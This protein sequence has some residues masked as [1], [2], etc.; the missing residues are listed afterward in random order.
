MFDLSYGTSGI[1]TA[2]SLLIGI[3]AVTPIYLFKP[4][5][6]QPFSLENNNNSGPISN[7]V[8]IPLGTRI[9]LRH[10]DAERILVTNEES[11]DITLE[12]AANIRDRYGNFLVP[13]GSK[14]MGFIQPANGGAQ[15]VTREIIIYN[16]R[17]PLY[18]SS[19]VVT[20]TETINEGASVE[21]ILGGTL[22]GS[23]AAAIIAGTTGDRRIDALEVLA[24][25]AVGTLAGWGLPEAG[26]IGG[27]ETQVI[28][29][30]P[31]QDLAIIL[32]SN[33][34]LTGNNKGSYRRF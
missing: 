23:A 22:A 27:G 2:I 18:A 5:A 34:T 26:L 3:T 25:A 14:V 20:R 12:T 29:I 33:L 13:V 8:V 19:G 21:E 6:A 17:Y 10:Q 28:S 32:E 15:F 31:N 1:A 9:P 16:Q 30:D 7:D 11:L 24:G 4:A